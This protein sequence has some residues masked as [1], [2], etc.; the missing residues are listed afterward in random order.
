MSFFLFSATCSRK[1]S[2]KGFL[3]KFGDLFRFASCHR[4]RCP[5][6]CRAL[7]MLRENRTFS[8]RK[9]ARRCSSGGRGSLSKNYCFPILCR[10]SEA[11]VG[12]DASVCPMSSREFSQ[13]SVGADA[14]IGPPGSC[15][16]A[17]DY[18]K[19]G[20]ICRVDV[21]IDPYTETGS[22]CVCAA[23]FRKI[24]CTLP[25]GQRRPPIRSRTISIVIGL[26]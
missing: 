12:A 5:H 11:G 3:S 22:A 16:F 8:A 19:N 4:S 17:A 15:E 1:K 9:C 25:G 20:A 10:V 26:F 23:A 14:Y 2:R 6:E 18:R 24:S 7:A 13:Y 21:G